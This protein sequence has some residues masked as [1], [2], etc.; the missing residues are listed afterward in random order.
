MILD[1]NDWKRSL[2]ILYMY[3]YIYFLWNIFKMKEALHLNL[4][5]LPSLPCQ[6]LDI[7]FTLIEHLAFVLWINLEG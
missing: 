3:I 2:R 4:F 1:L 7:L 5:I 6:I